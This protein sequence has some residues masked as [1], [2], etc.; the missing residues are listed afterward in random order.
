[1]CVYEAHFIAACFGRDTSAKLRMLKTK[2][3][4]ADPTQSILGPA[5]YKALVGD[6]NG[7]MP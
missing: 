6:S 2:Q 4:Q 1:V 3:L 5:G 7:I